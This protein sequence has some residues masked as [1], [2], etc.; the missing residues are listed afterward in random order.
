MATTTQLAI[1]TP[2]Q[3]CV[4]WWLCKPKFDKGQR[5]APPQLRNMINVFY[6]CEKNIILQRIVCKLLRQDPAL[7][8]G[9]SI[10]S[11]GNWNYVMKSL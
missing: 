2:T 8:L 6:F 1:C 10:S 9:K 3:V 7:Q 5:P 11:L 4:F